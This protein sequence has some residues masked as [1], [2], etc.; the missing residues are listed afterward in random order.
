MNTEKNIIPVL[1]GADLNC[2]SV[3]RAFHEAFGVKS[4]AFGRYEL[5]TT[6]RSKIVKFRAVEDVDTAE[7]LLPTLE[8]FAKEHENDLMVLVGCTDAYADLIIE[9]K[10]F[11]SRYFFCAC[12]S[13]ELAKQLIS[14]EAFYEMCVKHVHH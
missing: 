14:K 7:V 9:N 13:A 5:G 11:L 8:K 1:L 6:K 12:P 4:Y 10:E 3:A 2:Y